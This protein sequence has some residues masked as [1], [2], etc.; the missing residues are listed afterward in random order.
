[1]GEL[2]RLSEMYAYFVDEPFVSEF[3]IESSGSFYTLKVHLSIP[4]ITATGKTIWRE[5][6][7]EKKYESLDLPCSKNSFLE[8][9]D[10]LVSVESFDSI[11]CPSCEKLM[12]KE[13]N[14]G[15]FFCPA[16]ERL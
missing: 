9:R 3:D 6:Y 4:L 12:Y 11:G 7:R 1:M 5:L 15:K 16:C 10:E 8:D 13:R 14:S 2:I